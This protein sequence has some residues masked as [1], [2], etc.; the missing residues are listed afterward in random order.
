M[1]LV[2]WHCIY[3]IFLNSADREHFLFDVS[4]KAISQMLLINNLN[5]HRNP[6]NTLKLWETFPKGTGSSKSE[7]DNG[8]AAKFIFFRF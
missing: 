5:S 6:K 3:F 7:S 1:N 2:I 4:D 8:R